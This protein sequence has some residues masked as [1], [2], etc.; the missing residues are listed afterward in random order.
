MTK[1]ET[2]TLS[3]IKTKLDILSNYVDGLIASNGNIT[4]E[5]LRAFNVGLTLAFEQFE[6][7]VVNDLVEEHEKC[8]RSLPS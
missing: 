8:L 6:A 2:I 3:D 4:P 5:T 7:N 1:N